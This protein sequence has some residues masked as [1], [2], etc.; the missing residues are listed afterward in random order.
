LRPNTFDDKSSIEVRGG[1]GH[2]SGFGGSGGI[3][4]FEGDSNNDHYYRLKDIC[5]ANGGAPGSSIVDPDDRACGTGGAGTMYFY[6]HGYLDID[7][8]NQYT[9]QMTELK[10]E[11]RGHPSGHFS[12]ADSLVVVNGAH[13]LLS[14]PTGTT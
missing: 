7:N 9:S 1:R 5:K 12:V 14:D 6:D 13:A 4:I 8:K 10:I 3:I 2:Y 11:N